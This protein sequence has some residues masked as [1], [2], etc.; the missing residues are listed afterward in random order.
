MTVFPLIPFTE[1]YRPRRFADVVGQEEVV[2]LLKRHVS[3]GDL[4]SVLAIGPSGTGKTSL[5][6]IFAHAMHCEAP[7]PEPCGK[8]SACDT[9]AIPQPGSWAFYHCEF[10]GAEHNDHASVKFIADLNQSRFMARRGFFVDEVHG[11]KTS[12]ADALLTA[13]ERPADGVF[14]TF[15]TTEPENV[16]PALRS[17]CHDLEFQLLTPAQSFGLLERICDAEGIAADRDA[18]EM[19]AVAGRGSAREIV[20]LLDRVSQQGPVTPALLSKALSLGWTSHLLGYFRAVLAGDVD[21]QERALASWLATPQRKAQGIRDFLLYLHNY[22]VTTPRLSNVIDIAFH[23]IT[24]EQR[25]RVVAPLRAR[26]DHAKLSLDSYWLGLLDWWNFDHRQIPDEQ[27]LLIRTRRFNRLVNAQGEP[28]PEP[29]HP[30]GAGIRE[31]I[32]RSRSIRIGAHGLRERKAADP[33]WLSLK[34]AEYIYDAASFLPQEYGVWFNASL[35]LRHGALGTADAMSVADL[36]LTITHELPMRARGLGSG[37][38]HWIAM[39]AMEADGPVTDLAFRVPDEYLPVMRDWLATRLAQKR[40]AAATNGAA[41]PFKMNPSKLPTP[42]RNWHWRAVQGLWRGVDPTIKCWGRNGSREA[43]PDLLQLPKWGR[44]AVGI[45]SGGRRVSCSA[46]LAPSCRAMAEADGMKLLSA[47]ADGAW[48]ALGDGWELDERACRAEERDRRQ[49]QQ[50]LVEVR[51]PVSENEVEQ[52]RREDEL[53]RL[54]EG[55]PNDPRQR[56]RSWKG[57]W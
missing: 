5:M 10:S 8:C 30:E 38:V 22:E 2:E 51:W 31:K 17:R 40:G 56:R 4:S 54:R 6:R 7:T 23:P 47:F 9:F 42:R 48:T 16:R 41:W 37:G 34:Q 46:S 33:A 53:R 32:A 28:P 18:L 20:K 57:W 14:Y 27:A 1:K 26:A 39:N 12:A 15:A 25:A 43:L 45:L 19:L 49:R 44:G 24:T 11:L 35:Q 36:V 21:G 3:K 52:A 50:A 13:V 29:A 55:W